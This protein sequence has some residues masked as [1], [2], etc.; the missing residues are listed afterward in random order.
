MELISLFATTSIVFLITWVIGCLF[1][2]PLLGNLSLPPLVA[3]F[4]RLATGHIAICTVWSLW[5]TGGCTIFTGVATLYGA[6]VFLKRKEVTI[7]PLTSVLIADLKHLLAGLAILPLILLVLL[8]RSG[9]LDPE[10]IYASMQ[11]HGI[12]TTLAE[13]LK[14][15]GVEVSSP[16]YQTFDVAADGV[17][18]I[19]HYE[20]FWYLAFALDC[21]VGGNPLDGYNYIFT[22]VVSLLNCFG[23]AALC[24]CLK[25]RCEKKWWLLPLALG[26]VMFS[27]GIEGL[28]W[29]NNFDVNT[30]H[31]P[32]IAAL[33]I[34]VAF[35]LAARRY[36]L[37]YA[38]L[39]AF[40]ALALSDLR[41]QPTILVSAGLLY[42]WLY[43]KTKSHEHLV[44]IAMLVGCA[45]FYY[46]FYLFFG[47]MDNSGGT[48][49]RQGGDGWWFYFSK[50]LAAA[51]V[52]HFVFFFP[53]YFALAYLLFKRK[54]RHGFRLE[55]FG[56]LLVMFGARLRNLLRN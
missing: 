16:W 12:Y 32:K 41:F 7:R 10:I 56:F 47:S 33:P 50:E 21:R 40:G 36:G 43:W 31:Y 51:L 6:V 23:N 17:P 20:D 49:V 4:I 24:V 53:A 11:D 28:R 1:S 5:F 37:R 19:Y 13:Y 34:W 27:F 25:E 9:W 22:S 46:S 30:M 48:I 54:N 35:G 55:Y 26:C 3:F 14:I 2:I 45:V 52:K 29:T 44:A 18:K 38:D 42:S 39:L 15:T 8:Y